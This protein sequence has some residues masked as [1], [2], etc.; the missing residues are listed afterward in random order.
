MKDIVIELIRKVFDFKTLIVL[1]VVLGF[2]KYE[3]AVLFLG[4]ATETVLKFIGK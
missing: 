3:W 4:V 2:L 1:L